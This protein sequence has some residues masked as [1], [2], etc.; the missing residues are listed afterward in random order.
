MLAKKPIDMTD[1]AVSSAPLEASTGCSWNLAE[2]GEGLSDSGG[3]SVLCTET[4]F[5]PPV[6]VLCHAQ[7]SA[8]VLTSLPDFEILW[9]FAVHSH[10]VSALVSDPQCSP[11]EDSDMIGV[12]TQGWYCYIQ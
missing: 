3:L 11:A 2:M 7:S 10:S 8:V 4:F 12:V 1:F 6:S 5:P 9:F